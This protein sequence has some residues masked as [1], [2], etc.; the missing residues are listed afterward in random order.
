M[1]SFKAFNRFNGFNRLFRFKA[2]LISSDQQQIFGWKWQA[3][4]SQSEELW[5]SY[6][7]GRFSK[8]S[9][10]C[11]ARY[12]KIPTESIELI[13]SSVVVAAGASPP[14]AN[15]HLD[16][17]F[18]CSPWVLRLPSL[19]WFDVLTHFSTGSLDR[20]LLGP[21]IQDFYHWY[22]DL[23]GN[24]N[25]L[26]RCRTRNICIIWHH[27]SCNVPLCF[28]TFPSVPFKL[29]HHH[30][31]KNCGFILQNSFYVGLSNQRAHRHGKPGLKLSQSKL[32]GWEEI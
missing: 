10:Q 28:R 17:Y 22:M 11:I 12:E 4:W 13:W 25:S 5:T 16:Q 9:M 8:C 26:V 29:L 21:H 7:L 15:V 14:V 27:E 20:A 1:T 19:S 30:C 2:V 23:Y 24:M 6:H 31:C 18:L 32:L 3:H